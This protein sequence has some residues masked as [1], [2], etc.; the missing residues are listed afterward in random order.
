MVD[1]ILN[2]F[3]IFFGIVLGLVTLVSEEFLTS[4][5]NLGAPEIVILIVVGLG[6]GSLKEFVYA[7]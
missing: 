2:I 3:S 4:M 7:K 1:A 5:H 6:I